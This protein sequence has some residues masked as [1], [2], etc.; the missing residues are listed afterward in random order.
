M[1]YFSKITIKE[2]DTKAEITV[3]LD[4]LRKVVEDLNTQVENMVGDVNKLF[5]KAESLAGRFDNI[6]SKVNTVISAANKFIDNANQYLQPI[7][8][9][10]ANDG[11]F[12]LSE[13]KDIPTVV[14]ANGENAIILAPT[15]Y[16]LELLA[17]AYKKSIKVNGTEL[18]NETLDGATKTVVANL[19][20]GLNEIEYS[21]MDFYGNVVTKKYYVE[22][23]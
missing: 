12:R 18:N 22:V 6:A 16:T 7:M 2:G 15:S 23:R 9:G 10:V 14:K 4:D 19:K 21:T 11:A 5:D 17:P 3:K 8:L 20:S 13:V 1:C